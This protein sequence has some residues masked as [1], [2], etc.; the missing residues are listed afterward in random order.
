M[1]GHLPL[2]VVENACNLV[3]TPR[4]RG[5]RRN[6]ARGLGLGRFGSYLGLGELDRVYP[7]PPVSNK[8]F[9]P[10]KIR[11]E[12][13]SLLDTPFSVRD[14]IVKRRQHIPRHKLPKPIQSVMR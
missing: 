2:R 14:N 8:Q 6:N 10:E 3:V 11:S 13:E 7:P 1:W 9:C 12:Q 4:S 5:K